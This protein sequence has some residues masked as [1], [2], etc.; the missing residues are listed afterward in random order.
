MWFE[1]G[2][3]SVQCRTGSDR[4]RKRVPLGRGREGTM[5]IVDSIDFWHTW[6]LLDSDLNDLAKK[7]THVV[8]SSI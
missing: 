1:I 6:L 3:E 8:L 2:L 7:V 4:E 5:T